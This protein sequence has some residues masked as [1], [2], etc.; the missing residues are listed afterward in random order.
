MEARISLQVNVPVLFGD[1][2][3]AVALDEDVPNS[4]TDLNVVMSKSIGTSQQSFKKQGS[5]K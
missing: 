1:I 3:L 5:P 4:G 2:V